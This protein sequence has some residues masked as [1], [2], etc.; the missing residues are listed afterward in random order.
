[1]AGLKTQNF[2]RARQ[3]DQ[4]SNNLVNFTKGHNAPFFVQD[5]KLEAENIGIK[6]P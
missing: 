5:R 6:K 4:K 1:M 3:A 2:I